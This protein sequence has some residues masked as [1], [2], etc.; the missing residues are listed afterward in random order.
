[1][2]P[3]YFHF[4]DTSRNRK[5]PVIVYFSNNQSNK[6]VIY[7]PGYGGGPEN[8]KKAEA[9]ERKWPMEQ[10]E[11]LAKFFVAK[12][13]NFISI[14]HDLP[15]D[16]GGLETLD[17][18]A[19]QAIVRKPLWIRAEQN[20]L[21]VIDELKKKFP[22][23]NFDKFIIGGHSNGGDIA[24]F[25]ANNH[26]EMIDFV[27]SLDGRR[28][29]IKSN[30]NLKILMFEASDTSTDDGVIPKEGTQENPLRQNLEWIVIKPKTA[31]HESYCD[32]H[33]DAK[34]DNIEVQK[35]VCKTIEWIV[36]N[37]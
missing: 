2:I 1:M 31:V 19:V 12:G 21:F 22:A 30:A 26:E 7:N 28:C 18:N 9:G 33:V 15:G 5:I 14:Q 34:D 3:K 13:Y 36:D 17:P 8:M 29:P 35:Q 16:T 27:I 4:F 24:K 37:F 10:A 11:Y 20:L 23:L 6:V 32:N 25:F